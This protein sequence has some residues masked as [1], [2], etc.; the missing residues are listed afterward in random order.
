MAKFID[1]FPSPTEGMQGIIVTLLEAGELYVVQE[2]IDDAADPAQWASDNH[3]Q[4]VADI[5][6]KGTLVTAHELLELMDNR[7]QDTSE[8][9]DGI[10]DIVKLFRNPAQRKVL[11]AIVRLVVNVVNVERAEHGRSQ[12]TYDQ[13]LQAIVDEYKSL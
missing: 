8:V 11:W 2:E 3:A 10:D 9:V 7:G 5:P 6:E 12:F 13:A 4:I 1:T